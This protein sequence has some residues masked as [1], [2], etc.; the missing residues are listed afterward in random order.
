[1]ASGPSHLAVC[2]AALLGLVEERGLAKWEGF[3]VDLDRAVALLADHGGV[4]VAFGP[5]VVKALEIVDQISEERGAPAFERRDDRKVLAGLLAAV[6]PDLVDRV[7]GSV[8]TLRG[9]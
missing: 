9:Q 1:M 8:R 3:Q 6:Y 4:H 2:G 5:A 7:D